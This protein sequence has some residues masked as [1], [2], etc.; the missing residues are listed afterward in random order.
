VP[1]HRTE[2]QSNGISRAGELSVHPKPTSRSMRLTR[3]APASR[4]LSKYSAV[5]PECV[6]RRSPTTA[7]PRAPRPYV[8][9]ARPGPARSEPCLRAHL[10]AET[11]EDGHFRVSRSAVPAKPR[12]CGVL[13]NHGDGSHARRREREC[14]T[15]V[16]QQHDRRAR[17]LERD[18]AMVAVSTPE[19]RAVG[20][21]VRLL[22]QPRSNFA[23]STRSTAASMT[24][25]AMVPLLERIEVRAV[26]RPRRLEDHI[27]PRL[28]RVLRRR[29]ACSPPCDAAR[30][31]RRSPRRRRS[32]SH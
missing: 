16:P 23:V 18:R 4:L 29:R 9:L 2:Y 14:A 8:R 3:G 22:E 27:E 20:V 19:R 12:L 21:D 32:R 13:T 31:R 30:S 25:S 24:E 28:E 10:R 1:V 5:S 26:L 7:P 17:G 15:L 6:V 11:I